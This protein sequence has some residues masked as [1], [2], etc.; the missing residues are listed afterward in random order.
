MMENE[1]KNSTL[2]NVEPTETELDIKPDTGIPDIGLEVKS[3][4]GAEPGPGAKHEPSPR[5]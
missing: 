5:S 3:E 2:E 4:P 1:S